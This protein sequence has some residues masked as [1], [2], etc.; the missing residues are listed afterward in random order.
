MYKYV[1]KHI[2]YSKQLYMYIE[3]QECCQHI[4]K[5]DEATHCKSITFIVHL[6]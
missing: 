4:T 3:N 2:L 5:V 1:M 6:G